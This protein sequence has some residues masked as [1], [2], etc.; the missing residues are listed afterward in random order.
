MNILSGLALLFCIASL[1]TL[2]ILFGRV[3][4]LELVKDYH[5]SKYSY[6]LISGSFLIFYIGVS[7]AG[8]AALIN[9]FL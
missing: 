1:S 7:L 9:N 2:W 8:I 6:A 5:A 3:M 4:Y